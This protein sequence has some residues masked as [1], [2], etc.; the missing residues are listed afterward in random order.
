MT[1]SAT[2]SFAA[3][4][5]L[6]RL[7]KWLRLIG[8]DTTYDP[9]W[10]DETLLRHTLAGGRVLLT[11]DSRL[12]RR[13]RL[14]EHLFLHSDDFRMQLREVL[15]RYPIDPFAGLLCLC[16]R[17]NERLVPLTLALARPRVPPYVAAHNTRFAECPCCRRVY[18]PATHV[19]RMRREL[20]HM[21]LPGSA[22]IP[23]R[24]GVA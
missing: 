20:E 11:R 22:G 16:S 4:S 13:R 24:G 18:W 15:S 8:V 12:L 21:N 14:P 23:T 17:C 1:A 19:A 9:A 6:G 7:A 5:M 10:R 2:P 3:D